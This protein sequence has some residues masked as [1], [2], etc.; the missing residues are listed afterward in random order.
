MVSFK[1][2]IESD[3]LLFRGGFFPN[4]YLFPWGIVSRKGM[5]IIKKYVYKKFLDGYWNNCLSRLQSSRYTF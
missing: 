5:D 1:K 2:V 4:V 3:E